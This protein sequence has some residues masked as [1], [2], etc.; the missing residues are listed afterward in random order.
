M[1]SWIP[2]IL[3][4]VLTIMIIPSKAATTKCIKSSK[5]C[6]RSTECCTGCCYNDKCVEKHESCLIDFEKIGAGNGA[7]NCN[8]QCRGGET[9]QLQQVQCFRAPCSPISSCISDDYR[10]YDN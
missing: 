8:P 7:L 3:C 10:D 6:I 4:L 2:L 5:N 1:R 9:C